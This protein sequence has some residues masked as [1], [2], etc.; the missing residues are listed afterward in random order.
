[1]YLCFID[2]S[3]SPPKPTAKNPRPYFVI[4]GVI[5]HEAQWKGI[6]QE[7]RRLKAKPEYAITGEI[8]WRYFGTAN[9]DVDNSVAHLDQAARDAFRRE[10]YA[11]LT[12]RKSI[13]TIACVTSVPA[14]YETRYVKA[15]EDL[16]QF[17]YKPVSERFQYYLQDQTKAVGAEQL[18]MVV[19]DHRARGQDESLRSGHHRLVDQPATF[20]SNYENYVETIF[21]TP[22]HLSVG[23]QFADM[24]AGA[25]G[26]AFSTG[27]QTWFEAMEPTLRRSPAGKVEG[28]GLV[29]FPV[30]NW[31]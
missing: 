14:A 1:M 4:A 27:D 25:V 31:R 7:L 5:M 17:T 21:L 28:Y 16:Y 23:I 26:R 22:S 10:F 8:K 29:K 18:G 2:E 24:V 13:R 9:D 11:I 3:G 30:Q 20:T 12:Q 19:A 15:A 6:A